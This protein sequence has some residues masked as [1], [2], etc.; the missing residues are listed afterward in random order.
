[1]EVAKRGFHLNGEEIREIENT[2][3]EAG[4][5]AVFDRLRAVLA[6]GT[7]YSLADITARYG[8][9]RST[10]MNWCRIY[11]RYG[12]EGL[13]SRCKGGNNARLS[14]AQ[15]AD[16]TRRLAE[17]TPEMAFGRGA[18]APDGITWTVKDLYRAL[19]QWYGVVYNSPA[20]YYRLL[21]R[22]HRLNQHRQAEFGALSRQ[23]DS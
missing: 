17:T 9:S 8:C 10:L 15:L 12:V 23:L 16:L 14:D 18:A 6:Y 22:I 7:G 3:Q 4:S 2:L 20:S 5:D 11:R 19:R 21:G 13:V 1:V